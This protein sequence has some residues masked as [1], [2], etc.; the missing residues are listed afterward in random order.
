MRW[1]AAAIVIAG[2]LIAGS[3]AL[4]S[5]FSISGTSNQLSVFRLNNWT[6]E[7]ALC[8]AEGSQQGGLPRV[9]ACRDE[10]DEWIPVPNATPDQFGGVRVE[11]KAK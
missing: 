4:T 11:P 1:I 2:A 8:W 3:I 6:G 10:K 9:L 5:H 7:V